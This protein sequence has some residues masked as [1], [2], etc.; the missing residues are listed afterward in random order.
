MVGLILTRE[1]TPETAPNRLALFPVTVAW[2]DTTPHPPKSPGD[3]PN[4]LLL[5]R[6]AL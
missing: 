4:E 1:R 5:W 2:L 3:P 6:N